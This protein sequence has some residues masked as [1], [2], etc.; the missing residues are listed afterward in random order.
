MARLEKHKSTNTK[1]FVGMDIC[2]KSRMELIPLII[3]DEH[4]IQE[5]AY[6]YIL[7]I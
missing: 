4:L 5:T 3:L 6:L 2:E 7:S 1:S